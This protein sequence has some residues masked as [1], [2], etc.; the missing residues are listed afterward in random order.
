MSR[1]GDY[2]R[3]NQILEA[4]IEWRDLRLE[5]A[6]SKAD[7]ASWLWGAVNLSVWQGYTRIQS[8]WD[9]YSRIENLPDFRERRLRGLNNLT[10][11]GYVGDHG[12]YVGMHRTDRGGPGLAVDTYGA[13]YEITRQAIMNDSAGDLLNRNPGDMGYAAGLFVS[14][15][16][17]ALLESNPN[18]FDGNPFFG[19]G[20][21]H[22]NAG[23]AALSED[24]IVD[25][26]SAMENQRDDDNFRI[27][28]TPVSL[29][30][31]NARLELIA[32]RILRS[33]QTGVNLQYT[34]AAG[35]G[36]AIFDKGTDNVVAGILPD[37]AIIREPFLT[38]ATDWY[39]FADPVTTPALAVGFLNGNRAPFVGLKDPTVRSALGAGMDPYSFELDSVEFKVRQDFGVAVVD[40]RGAY[41]ATVAG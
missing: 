37:N 32:R 29:V 15:A 35:V 26:I 23:T 11:F 19:S 9:R 10:G 1:Y 30:V 40:W 22:N 25:A 13:V 39:L 4:Y 17:I 27:Q 3:P 5:E 16:I 6:D 18:A 34:G 41:K 8:A 36:S 12:E 38:D 33:S 24:S 28:V 21:G 31:P 7:F 20:G 14:Q 2:G